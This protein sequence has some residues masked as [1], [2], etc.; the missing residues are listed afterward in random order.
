MR[1]FLETAVRIELDNASKGQCAV[2]LFIGTA[3]VY[4]ILGF[5]INGVEEP[6]DF[7]FVCGWFGGGVMCHHTTDPFKLV[8]VPCHICPMYV[9]NSFH[10]IFQGS[11]ALFRETFVTIKKV[12]P[13]FPSI[14]CISWS[15]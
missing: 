11:S 6:I 8:N 9:S 7:L 5:F 15:R 1:I 14:A 12:S 4:R 2:K 13:S 3:C 10:E